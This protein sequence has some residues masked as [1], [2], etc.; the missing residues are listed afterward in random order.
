MWT[1]KCTVLS[2]FPPLKDRTAHTSKRTKINMHENCTSTQDWVSGFHFT[3]QIY[4][5]AKYLYTNAFIGASAAF[6]QSSLSSLHKVSKS[7]TSAE[8][9]SCWP[10]SPNPDLAFEMQERSKKKS[11]ACPSIAVRG[12][13]WEVGAGNICLAFIPPYCVAQSSIRPTDGIL[14]AHRAHCPGDSH[15]DWEHGWDKFS[16]LDG[17]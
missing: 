6:L 16:V 12:T 10:L 3:L 14:G 2:Y 17:A 4:N 15:R 13:G 8:Q 1:C 7:I 5:T 11:L 9:L